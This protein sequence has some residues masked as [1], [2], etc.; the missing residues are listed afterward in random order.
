MQVSEAAAFDVSGGD[1]FDVVGNRAIGRRYLAHLYNRYQ[2]WPDAIAAYNWGLGRVDNWVNAGRPAEK[3]LP[4]VAAYTTRVLR[5][6]GLCAA[7]QA[8]RSRP[9]PQFAGRP[10]ARDAPVNPSPQGTC[11]YPYAGRSPKGLPVTVKIDRASVLSPLEEEVFSAR[12]SW[13]R[14]TRSFGCATTS[15]NSPECR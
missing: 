8:K 15:N 11:G 13:N 2:N 7:E 6:S 14:A 4:G 1:R 5:D 9:S 10:N 3:L 12:L